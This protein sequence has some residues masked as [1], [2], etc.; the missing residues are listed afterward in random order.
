MIGAQLHLA[1]TLKR[2]TEDEQAQDRLDKRMFR[3]ELYALAVL[4]GQ[5]MVV[6][7]VI[8]TLLANCLRT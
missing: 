3:A 1:R 4:I 2:K 7:Y 6:V 8:G 5:G